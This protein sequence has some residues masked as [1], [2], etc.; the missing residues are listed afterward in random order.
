[1]SS[2]MV[3]R[4]DRICAQPAVTQGDSLLFRLPPEIRELIYEFAMSENLEVTPL[5][6]NL[7]AF[8]RPRSSL[9]PDSAREK[10]KNRAHLELLRTCRAIYCEARELPFRLRENTHW[11]LEGY[12][13]RMWQASRFREL[14]QR[15]GCRHTKIDVDNLRICTSWNDMGR[16]PSWLRERQ[17][18]FLR[19]RII[20]ITVL[21]THSF[22]FSGPQTRGWFS[23]GVWARNMGRALPASAHTIRLELNCPDLTEL[24]NL[25][26]HMR[27]HWFFKTENGAIL[28]AEKSPERDARPREMDSDPLVFACITSNRLDEFNRS[29][30]QVVTFR[31]H[32]ILRDME[33]E[34]N[35]GA[36]QAAEN[37]DFKNV[38]MIAPEPRRFATQPFPRPYLLRYGLPEPPRWTY[39]PLQNFFNGYSEKFALPRATSPQSSGAECSACDWSAAIRRFAA[40]TAICEAPLRETYPA[41]HWRAPIKRRRL[42]GP[43]AASI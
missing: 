8:K 13:I 35:E 18:N 42:Q 28:L 32:S 4:S 26:K 43:S 1:M 5:G 40:P 14:Q 27:E 3:R 38:D 33:S 9:E 37:D 11:L 23:Y 10:Q 34:V 30:L 20:T 6:W 12:Q 41:C 7:R 15:I 19:P 17:A 36:R 31:T 24:G 29:N 22:D 16:V 2:E 21:R 39:R 25:T